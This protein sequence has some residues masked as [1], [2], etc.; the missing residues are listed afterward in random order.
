[1][2]Y[3]GFAGIGKTYATTHSKN[4]IDLESSQY[5]WLHAKNKS[6]ES[7]KSQYSTKNPKWPKNYIEAIIEA[8]T[9]GQNVLISAQ[10]EVLELLAENNIE[11]ITV[12]PDIKDKNFYIQRYIN[13]GNPSKF[14]EIMSK[15]FE[16]FITDMDNNKNAKKH[17]KLK[18]NS[19]LNDILK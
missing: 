5:Q 2:I 18:H 16:T 1:M 15:N 17:I 9:Q 12:T 6:I 10:P 14:I 3:S 4:T 11:F 13:R 7:N 19:F 8:N